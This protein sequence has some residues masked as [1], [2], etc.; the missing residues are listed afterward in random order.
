MT[1]IYFVQASRRKAS[2]CP[3]CKASFICITKVEDAVSADQKIYSQSIPHDSLNMDLY[4]LPDET[5]RP[6]NVTTSSISANFMSCY[7]SIHAPFFYLLFSILSFQSLTLEFFVFIFCYILQPSAAVCCRC[8]SREPEDLLIRC[9][10]C[11][12][13]CVHSYCL[14][15]PLFPWTCIQCKDLQMLYLHTR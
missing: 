15:P 12:I 7:R 6:G 4:I 2:T 1:V 5:H 3:L 9:H 13:R 14:D 10:F 11:E 8:S